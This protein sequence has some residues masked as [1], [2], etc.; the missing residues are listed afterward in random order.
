MIT[1]DNPY[2]VFGLEDKVLF[3]ILA[4]RFFS[5]FDFLVAGRLFRIVIIRLSFE[6]IEPVCVNFSEFQLVWTLH[7]HILRVFK[8]VPHPLYLLSLPGIWGFHTISGLAPHGI[9]AT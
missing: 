3:H 1:H 9:G 6:K 7:L 2:L 8:F 4:F 5:N